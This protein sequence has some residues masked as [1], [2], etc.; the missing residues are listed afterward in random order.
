MIENLYTSYRIHKFDKNY[1]IQYSMKTIRNISF[2]YPNISYVMGTNRIW[3]QDMK[4]NVKIFHFDSGIAGMLNENKR[5]KGQEKSPFGLI[6]DNHNHYQVAE[7]FLN[8]NKPS[9]KLYNRLISKDEIPNSQVKAFYWIRIHNQEKKTLDTAIL[10][11][12][13]ESLVALSLNSRQIKYEYQK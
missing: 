11:H 9:I 7:A 13:K 4:N 2:K 3:V 8:S 6:I 10:L 1:Y 12:L 5:Q